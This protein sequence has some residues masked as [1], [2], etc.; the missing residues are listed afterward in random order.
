MPS[1]EDW[2]TAIGNMHKKVGEDRTCTSRYDHGR[3]NTR[4]HAHTHAR[5]HAHAHTDRHAHH[6][7]LCASIGDGVI[8][9]FGESYWLEYNTR[10]LSDRWQRSTVCS[11]SVK[12]T[13][14]NPYIHVVPQTQHHSKQHL[15]DTKYHR[16]FLFKWVGVHYLVFRQLPY[17]QQVH[18][19]T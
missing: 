13:H 7:T 9:A 10:K 12:W 11:S 1:E 16:Y 19:P 14:Y 8:S 15:S 18:T 4:I 5:A 17:L 6:N 2:A 3:T